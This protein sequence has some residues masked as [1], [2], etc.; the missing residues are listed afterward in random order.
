MIT[1]YK[2]RWLLATVILFGISSC[3]ALN[4]TEATPLAPEATTE[5]ASL[6]FWDIPVLKEAFVDAAPASRNDGILVGELGVDGG[7]KDIILKLAKEIANGQH[8]KYDSLLIAHKGKL[9]FESYYSRGRI[10]LPHG[11]ASATK[12]YTGLV[13]GRAIQL[14]YLT[15][16]DLNKPVISFLKN[17]DPSKFADDVKKVTLKQALTMTTGIRVSEENREKMRNDPT[18]LIG[19][20]EVQ[21]LFEYSDPITAETRMFSYSAGPQLVMQVIDAVVPG[22]AKDFIK[23]EFLGKMGITQYKWQTA[24]SGLPKAGSRTSI[25]SRDMAKIGMLAMNKGEWKGVQLIPEA[26]ITQAI[27]RFSFSGDDDVYGGGKDV[28]NQG[29]GYFWWDADLKVGNKSYYSASAQGGGGQYIILVEELDLMVV[30]TAHDNENTTL[31]IVAEKILPAFIQNS[32]L[33]MSKK[34]ESEEEFPPLEGPYLGQKPPGLT[35]EAF[36]PGIISKEGWELEGVFAPGMKEF[37][38]TLDRGEVI[39]PTEKKFRST[40]VGFRQENNIWQKYIE[41]KRTGEITFSPDGNRMHMAKSYK[42]RIGYGWSKRKFLGPLFNRKEFGIMRLSASAKGTYFFDDYKSTNDEAIR[43]STIEDG[44][45]MA[46]IKMGPEVNSGEMT[47][48]PYIAPDES[49]LI[50][51]SEREGGFGDSDLYISFRQEDGSWGSAINMGATVN[52]DKWDAYAS[53]TPDGKYILFNRR[54]DDG[55]D[56]D[57][58]N[59]DIYWVDAKIIETLRPK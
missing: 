49:Y 7:N 3:A 2:I 10:N 6:S 56:N 41:F 1:I 31:Q 16:D 59:V 57:N 8:G 23:N 43:I 29:Y 55:S 27:S 25:T 35:A 24:D 32:T 36:A 50:W 19:Q 33:T 48:H 4:T 47:A 9:L 11:Q 22:T 21:A 17:L 40:I 26:F 18:K 13:L 45:R 39:S 37:Y 44:K 14:G 15:M 52:S 54:I 28:Y 51:D 38:F 46:P 5:E 58:M 20:G 30:V 34:S 12:S 42:D 53:V